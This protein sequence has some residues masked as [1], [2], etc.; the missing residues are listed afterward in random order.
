MN[1]N[2]TIGALLLVTSGA[3]CTL[4]MVGAKMA[5]AIERGMY[6]LAKGGLAPQ[7]PELGWQIGIAVGILGVVGL[8]FLFREKRSEK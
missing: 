7:R 4:G 2:K 3:C 6:S 8:F 5:Y 1:N